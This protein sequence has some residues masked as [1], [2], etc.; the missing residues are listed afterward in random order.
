MGTINITGNIIP[1]IWYSKITRENGKPYL[2]AITLLADI[3]YWYRPSEQRDEQTGKVIG[4]R[5]RFKGDLLQKT[6]QQ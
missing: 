5:K 2:L 3:V 6:Y 4:W 1:Q